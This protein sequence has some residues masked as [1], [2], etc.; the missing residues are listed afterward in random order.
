MPRIALSYRRADASAMAGR[1]FDRLVSCY[2]H[3]SVFM[4]IDSI[5]FGADFREHVRTTLLRSDVLVA[6]IGPDWLGD[7][8]HA[9]ARIHDKADPVRVELETALQRSM[10]VIPILVDGAKM[11]ADA[12]LPRSL[13]AIAYINAAEVADGR[14]FR[15]HM[16][17][18]I[19]A[20]D[21]ILAPKPTSTAVAAPPDLASP[22]ATVAAAGSLPWQ[23]VALRYLAPAAL[24]LLLAHH[25]I[26]NSFD[27]STTFLRVSSLTIPLLLGFLAGWRD[28]ISSA[29]TLAGGAALGIVAV[30]GMSISEGLNSGQPIMPT[31]A[32]EWRENIE[33]AVSIALGF[34]AGHWLAGGLRFLQWKRS[35]PSR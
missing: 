5:P 35:A 1:I 33:Y 28:R 18:L 32:F 7:A 9:R 22:G 19:E 20:I 11:P 12:D 10:P 34:V 16:D 31:T 8:G 17:R 26:V 6:V 15:V 27:L 3:G 30:A 13:R 4:D 24:L 21:R 14:D 29:M 25:L 2:G 23:H